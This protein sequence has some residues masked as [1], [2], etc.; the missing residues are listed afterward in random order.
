M[1]DEILVLGHRA[2]TAFA[3]AALAR[4]GR[5][6]RALDVAALGDGDGHVF[7]GDQVLNRVLSSYLGN[8]SPAVVAKLLFYFFDFLDDYRAQRLL[9]AQNLFQLRNQL[10]D[11][12]IFIDDLLAFERR[13]P[14]QLQIENG[15]GLNFGK[16]KS[17]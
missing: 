8:F 4:I 16:R 12:F 9:V 17:L 5:Y 13:Q 6:R 14:A 2:E 15:L 7:I 3:A 11:R 10:D 1:L